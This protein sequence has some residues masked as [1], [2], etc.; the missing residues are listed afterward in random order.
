MYKEYTKSKKCGYVSERDLKKG[1]LFSM[2][3]LQNQKCDDVQTFVRKHV[4]IEYIC[5]LQCVYV[6]YKEYTQSTKCGYVSKRDL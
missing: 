3:K 1:P 6:M 4:H 2:S 5:I